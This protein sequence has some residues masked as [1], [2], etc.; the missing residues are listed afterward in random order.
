MINEIK[1]ECEKKEVK[2][3][4]RLEEYMNCFKSER[5]FESQ[6]FDK[7]I[8][9]KFKEDDILIKKKIILPDLKTIQMKMKFSSFHINSPK[10]RR[11]GDLNQQK[12]TVN[13]TSEN[14]KK[15]SLSTISLEKSPNQSKTMNFEEEN[16]NDNI[17]KTVKKMNLC[18]NLKGLSKKRSKALLVKVIN[19]YESLMDDFQSNRTKKDKSLLNFNYSLT[20]KD[21]YETSPKISDPYCLISILNPKIK[22]EMQAISNR[23][24]N[25]RKK[26][27]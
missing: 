16:Y 20:K 22:I 25:M 23:C 3:K 7:S 24:K 11:F 18:N 9:K 4:K 14:Q 17:K 1:E 12:T 5:N 10:M 27:D 15:T 19:D 13:W 8:Y 2:Y 21:S 6:N 26:G